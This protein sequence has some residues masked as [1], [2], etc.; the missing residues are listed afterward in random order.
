MREHLPFSN[1]PAMLMAENAASPLTRFV[2]PSAAGNCVAP[3]RA[4]RKGTR[5]AWNRPE[6]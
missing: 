5:A 2:N 6:E 1:Q 3:T 4:T